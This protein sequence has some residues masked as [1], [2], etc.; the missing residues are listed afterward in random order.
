MVIIIFIILLSEIFRRVG[1]I[2]VSHLTARLNRRNKF[3]ATIYIVISIVALIFIG[4][5]KVKIVPEIELHYSMPILVL[6]QN[7]I[8]YPLLAFSLMGLLTQGILYWSGKKISAKLRRFFLVV[9]FLFLF[10]FVFLIIGYF[11]KISI[12][13]KLFSDFSFWWFIVAGICMSIGFYNN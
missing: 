5:Y 7:N 11:L 6:I 8:A 3:L 12:A 1:D 9:A 13:T 10:L 2:M 4:I